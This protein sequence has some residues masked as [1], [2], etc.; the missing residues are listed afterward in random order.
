[1]QPIK[2]LRLKNLILCLETWSQSTE[3]LVRSLPGSTSSTKSSPSTLIIRTYNNKLLLK[4][5]YPYP[6]HLR[7][8]SCSSTIN[9]SA[10]LVGTGLF[11]SFTV[12]APFQVSEVVSAK[13]LNTLL[14][15]FRGFTFQRV[16]NSFKRI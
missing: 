6:I 4:P 1:M 12:A 11:F 16:N 7:V 2:T 3:R 15:R 5:Y 9:L 8:R 10:A 14:G 13:E